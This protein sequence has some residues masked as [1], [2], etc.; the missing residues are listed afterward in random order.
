MLL[1]LDESDDTY[2]TKGRRGADFVT[3]L[4]RAGQFFILKARGEANLKGGGG[5][6]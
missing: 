4:E 5:R 2:Q 6:E 3:L 1:H